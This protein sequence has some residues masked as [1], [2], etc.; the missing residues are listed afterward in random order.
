M[1]KLDK[2]FV[3]HSI[4]FGGFGLGFALKELGLS[5]IAIMGF[6]VAFMS[7]LSVMLAILYVLD[8]E[9]I[10]RSGSASVD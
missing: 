7:I 5:W 10:R 6:W 8:S 1:D 4:A 2:F 9:K 3:R